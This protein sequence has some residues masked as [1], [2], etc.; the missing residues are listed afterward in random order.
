MEAVEQVHGRHDARDARRWPWKQRRLRMSVLHGLW[1]SK[2]LRFDWLHGALTRHDETRPEDTSSM[3]MATERGPRSG[4]TR[5]QLIDRILTMNS[6]ATTDFLVAFSTREL[7]MYHEHLQAASTPRGRNA[8][9]IRESTAP[10][11]S[12]ALAHK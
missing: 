12:M 3:H 5:E 6:T 11:T 8:R 9:W 10:A 1:T 4:L 7:D 2:A